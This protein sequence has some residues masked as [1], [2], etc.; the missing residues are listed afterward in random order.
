MEIVD[1]LIEEYQGKMPDKML[2][3]GKHIWNNDSYFLLNSFQD[4]R[5]DIASK[6]ER[7]TY[8]I[9]RVRHSAYREFFI[10]ILLA[11][12]VEVMDREEF[13]RLCLVHNK[14]TSIN[15]IDDELENDVY[16]EHKG[17]GVWKYFMS[18]FGLK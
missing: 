2:A 17:I 16:V 6:T 13:K 9:C 7:D 4:G 10:K 12:G 14:P 15:G 1:Q 5:Y 8:A 18:L 11:K 3:R